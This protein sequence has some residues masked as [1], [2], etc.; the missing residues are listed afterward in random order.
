MVPNL[1]DVVTSVSLSTILDGTLLVL[2]SVLHVLH[3]ITIS[4]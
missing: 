1:G 4:L 3:V 2:L